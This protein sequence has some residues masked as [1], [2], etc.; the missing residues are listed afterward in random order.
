MRYNN[1]F[2]GRD[3][4][5]GH[6]NSLIKFNLEKEENSSSPFVESFEQGYFRSLWETGSIEWRTTFQKKE[7]GM[8][9]HRTIN[10]KLAASVFC[11]F[12]WLASINFPTISYIVAQSRGNGG[13]R[14]FA[15][16]PFRRSKK[17]KKRKRIK[18][19]RRFNDPSF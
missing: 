1:R 7:G 9:H 18:E 13:N 16:L 3:P 6:L 5:L 14:E 8:K 17:Q 2:N 19:Y 11:A 4:Q 12:G 10:P 15:F